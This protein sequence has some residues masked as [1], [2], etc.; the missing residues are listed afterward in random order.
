VRRQSR[1]EQV[2]KQ[3]QDNKKKLEVSKRAFEETNY[4]RF[5]VENIRGLVHYAQFIDSA[6]SLSFL[7]NVFSIFLFLLY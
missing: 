6:G 4:P 5:N 2:K 3:L 7:A 1:I